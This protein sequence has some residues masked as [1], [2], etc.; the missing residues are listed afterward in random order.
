MNDDCERC[1]FA[2]RIPDVV[3][4]NSQRTTRLTQTMREVA[5]EC[6]AEVGARVLRHV[7]I[8]TSPDT[9]LR[10]MRQTV[11]DVSSDPRAVGIDDWAIRKGQVY[12]TIVVDLESH[13]VL[14]LLE[15]RQVQTAATWLKAHTH[16]EIVSPDRAGA[17]AQGAREAAPK[18]Q[19]VADRF[20]LMKNLRDAGAASYEG[21][22]RLLRQIRVGSDTP[23]TAANPV[24]DPPPPSRPQPSKPPSLNPRKLLRQR[25]RAYWLEKFEEV[26]QL[27]DQGLSKA[28]IGRRSGLAMK[29]VRKY[30]RLDELPVKRCPKPGPRV[31]DPY[32]DYLPQRLQSAPAL[33]CSHL[34]Q[35]IQARGYG[36]GLTSLRTC[37]GQLRHSLNLPVPKSLTA[38]APPPGRPLTARC[39]ASI[40]LIRPESLSATQAKLIEKTEALHPDIHKTTHLVNAFATLL[41]NGEAQQLSQWIQQVKDSGLA[42]LIGFATGLKKDWDAVVAAFEL[43]WSNGL[44]EGHVNR[45]KFIKRQMYGRAKFDLLRLRVLYAYHR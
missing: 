27:R 11:V 2:E 34:L 10:V 23:A 44:V 29:T 21:Q 3:A 28:E 33:N 16:I 7:Q 18:A 30:C 25:R 1:T 9:L 45:L 38:P 39:L 13:C 12:G 8:S 31:I 5:F 6:E 14:D 37:V 26:H 19:Q 17:Y 4:V 22:G 32:R 20:H 41:R 36:G 24:Q 40:V 42:S 15:D 43:P 35:E